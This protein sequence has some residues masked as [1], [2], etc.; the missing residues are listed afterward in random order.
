MLGQKQVEEAPL[1]LVQEM[2][3]HPQRQ[4]LVLPK[5]HQSHQRQGEAV[6]QGRQPQQLALQSEHLR[7]LQGNQGIL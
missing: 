5:T 2:A 3:W 6:V 1:P 7:H 4:G